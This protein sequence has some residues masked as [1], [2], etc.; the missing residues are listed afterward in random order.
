LALTKFLC[1]RLFFLISKPPIQFLSLSTRRPVNS[2]QILGKVPTF[3][4]KLNLEVNLKLFLLLLISQAGII[5][6]SLLILPLILL[7]LL[8]KINDLEILDG[9]NNLINVWLK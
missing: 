2:D 5:L 6:S 1:S 4:F 9:N 7:S 3:L 8:I